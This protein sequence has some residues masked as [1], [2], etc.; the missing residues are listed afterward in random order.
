MPA[1]ACYSLTF[2]VENVAC[3]DLP[4]KYVMYLPNSST[5]VNYFLSGGLCEVW[6]I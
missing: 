3:M 5:N 1:L 4:L 6:F 2:Y